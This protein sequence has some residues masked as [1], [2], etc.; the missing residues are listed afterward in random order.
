[1]HVHCSDSQYV[2]R[3]SRNV[4]WV[5]VG[6]KAWETVS[7]LSAEGWRAPQVSWCHPASQ[8]AAGT[9]ILLYVSSVQ[10]EHIRVAGW[11]LWSKQK[12]CWSPGS[13]VVEV[14]RGEERKAIKAKSRTQRQ[15]W[16]PGWEISFLATQVSK[17]WLENKTSAWMKET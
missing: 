7:C 11:K 17:T 14:W 10:H 1:M 2:C 12:C 16:S 4:W 15:C 8:K 5:S 13:Y 9:G 3:S 6:K